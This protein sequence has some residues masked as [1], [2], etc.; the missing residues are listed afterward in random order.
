MQQHVFSTESDFL[1]VPLEAR[2][3]QH[4]YRVK[5]GDLTYFVWAASTLQAMGLVAKFANLMTTSSYRPKEV[6]HHEVAEIDP[7]IVAIV[8]GLS[9]PQQQKLRVLLK[10]GFREA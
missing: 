1:A 3:N 4:G 7:K 10:H 5:S 8:A 9:E 2:R 6:R